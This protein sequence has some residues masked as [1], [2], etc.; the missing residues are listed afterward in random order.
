MAR[1]R[2][3]HYGPRGNSSD[4]ARMRLERGLDQGQVARLLAV[5]RSCISRYE[6]GISEPTLSGFGKLRRAYGVT[7]DALLDAFIRARRTGQPRRNGRT[8]A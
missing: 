6:A 2:Q 5:D 7:A 3:G 8:A 1:R 4:L